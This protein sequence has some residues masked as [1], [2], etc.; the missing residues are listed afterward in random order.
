V[1]STVTPRDTSVHAL[2]D[3]LNP[4]STRAVLPAATPLG[5]RPAV[6][7]VVFDAD[8]IRWSGAVTLGELLARIPGVTLIRAG[9]YGQPETVSYRGQG[10]GSVEYYRDGYQLDPLGE[11]SVSFDTQRFDIGLYRRIEVEALP[12]VLRVYFI[13]DTQVAVRPRTEASFATGDASTNSYR[14]RYLNR[15]RN[16]AGLAVGVS[17]LG[18]AGPSTS[19]A[20]SNQLTLTGKFTWMPTERSGI[21]L[22]GSTWTLDADAIS[23]RAGG[24]VL[25]ARKVHRTDVFLR[26]FA[27]SRTDG[28]GFRLDGIVGGST[29]TDSSVALAT[30][31]GQGSVTLSY[32]ASHL[33]GSVYG[34]LRDSR[35]PLEAGASAA[36]SPLRPLTLSASARRRTVLGG[37]GSSDLSGAAEF[38]LLPWIAVHGDVR[39]RRLQDS[40]FVASDTAQTVLD[41]EGGVGV[42]G[43]LISFD[44]SMTSQGDFSAPTFGIFRH[45]VPQLF[46][47]GATA[48]QLSYR[49]QPRSWFSISGWIRNPSTDSIP[50]DPPMHSLTRVAF[51]SQFL[52]QFRRGIFDLEAMMDIE[53]WGSGVMGRDA[54]GA[55]IRFTGHSTF[56][57]WLQFKLVGALVYW[58]LRNTQY[59]HYQLLPGFAA[60]RAQQRF[61]IRWEFTN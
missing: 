32:A 45:Q 24:V 19:P 35:A 2:P 34:R 25:D 52:P 60:P 30:R 33:S 43:K 23:P 47:K 48:P 57:F 28:L 55:P 26:A 9:G 16:G 3:S 13:T 49:F 39:W 6:T 1:G 4:D 17:Y 18:T 31:E 54:G 27:A 51:R 29:Y 21:E 46:T 40:M 42:S 22:Q 14:I 11:D 20:K 38:R 8:A 44:L 56:N 5:P 41:W 58:T 36:V 61:G 53:A 37:F 7:R 59:E 50:W 12:T 10:A 15:W